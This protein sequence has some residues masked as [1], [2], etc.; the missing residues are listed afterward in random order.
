MYMTICPDSSHENVVAETFS[1]SAV[2]FSDSFIK[3]VYRLSSRITI[4]I[5]ATNIEIFLL[6][7][8]QRMLK[9]YKIEHFYFPLHRFFPYNLVIHNLRP[10]VFF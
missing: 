7:L 6:T 8:T 9:I 10:L 3:L 5:Y 4:Q 2:S 1:L